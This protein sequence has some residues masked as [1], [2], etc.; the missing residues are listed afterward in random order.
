[1]NIIPLNVQM[2]IYPMKCLS[3]AS[4]ILYVYL[5]ITN[6]KAPNDNRWYKYIWKLLAQMKPVVDLT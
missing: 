3:L 1:M 4:N 6:K 2:I 5:G